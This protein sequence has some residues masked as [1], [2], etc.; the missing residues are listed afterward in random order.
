MT[1]KLEELLFD[2][3][4]GSKH[5][6]PPKMKLTGTRRKLWEFVRAKERGCLGRGGGWGGVA[7]TSAVTRCVARP[8]RI[9]SKAK[10]MC[11]ITETI[12]CDRVTSGV[13]RFEMEGRR[14]PGEEERCDIRL[15]E[16]YSPTKL[17]Q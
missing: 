1:S 14:C 11:L 5:S 13:M 8:T 12:D 9:R 6:P 10:L 16:T 7:E 4:S 3:L 2:L 17:L 15:A